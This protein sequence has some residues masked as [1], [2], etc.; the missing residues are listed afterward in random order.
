MLYLQS[1]PPPGWNKIRPQN[2]GFRYVRVIDY[3]LLLT[4]FALLSFD[5]CR[6]EPYN[7]VMM[8]SFPQTLV[9]TLVKKKLAK[10]LA[11]FLARV[12]TRAS[13][14]EKTINT[15]YS[16]TRPKEKTLKAIKN[17]KKL[18]VRL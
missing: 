12:S 6:V 10:N 1:I 7:V 3:E 4:I 13:G 14:R 9:K 5:E 8:R 17:T 2:K 18:Y 15:V 11:R 16:T